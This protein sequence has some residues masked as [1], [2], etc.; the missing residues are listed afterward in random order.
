MS[1]T[2]SKEAHFFAALDFAVPVKTIMLRTLPVTSLISWL[3]QTDAP[4]LKEVISDPEAVNASDNPPRQSLMLVL[5]AKSLYGGNSREP[6][7]PTVGIGLVYKPPYVKAVSFVR[8]NAI[9]EWALYP[10]ERRVT[11]PLV[12]FINIADDSEVMPLAD[13]YPLWIDYAR[14]CHITE[15]AEIWNPF[16]FR[17]F[18][19]QWLTSVPLSKAGA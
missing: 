1:K 18:Q 6:V 16:A 12:T 4:Y 9:L 7:I 14:R 3:I 8:A 15:K 17:S 5:E 10:G 11:T 19:L 2:Y 13:P